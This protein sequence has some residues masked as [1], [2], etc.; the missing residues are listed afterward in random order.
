VLAYLDNP[1]AFSYPS[2]YV[3]FAEC[4]GYDAGGCLFAEGLATAFWVCGGLVDAEA[5]LGV[6]LLFV[7]THFDI[8]RGLMMG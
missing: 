7:C 8:F 1:S 6:R 2:G 3:I 5:I 4:G